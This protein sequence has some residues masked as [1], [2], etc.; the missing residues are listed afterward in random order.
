MRVFP[1]LAALFIAW[2]AVLGCTQAV[3]LEVKEG[4]STCI[5]AELSAS[6]SITYNT[7]SGT[8]TA[9]VSLPDSTTVDAASSSCGGSPWLVAV[10]GSGHTLGLS[11]SNNGSVYSVANLTL[12]YNLS[13]TSVFPDANSSDV[14][15]VVSASVGIWAPINTTY[16]C[17]SPTA[18]T[19]GGAT[20]T[21]FDMRL[22]AYMPGN[23]LSPT[24]S[25]CV[26]DQATTTAP[27]TTAS[28]AAPTTP[29]PTAPGTPERGTYSLKDNNGTI[30]LL[31]QMG[32]QLN[33]SYVSQAQNKTVQELLN[34]TPNLTNSSGSC[35]VSS[36]TLVLTQEQ[37]TVLSFTFTLNS[38]SNKYHL[39]GISLQANWS[40]LTAPISASN[41]SLDYL[42][43]TLGRSYMCNAE[44]TLVVIQTFSLNTF[45][46][47]V[48]PFGVTTNQ[49]ATAED[50]Q[51][52]QDQ[53]LIPIIVGAAL[54]GLVLIVLIAY[55]IGRKR[56]H[57]GY[58]T[59]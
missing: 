48:Q 50:C 27:T 57:A 53:M 21:F 59:I 11:F 24:E 54:A 32:L 7:S 37:T 35:G 5:K 43:S 36:A 13:D 26:A 52:D 49:F 33:V 46:L 44:Q 17:L 31:A 47:Q 45:R 10:F 39:S 22:E 8:R 1:S 51:M 15:T 40:D 16:R 3:T 38:T 56:S 42:R 41:N 30:C 28:T 6:F 34:L 2:F 9:S 55:L 58:Q 18:V 25:V 29:Q 23:D 19:A 20:V 4:N 12:Q 14:V